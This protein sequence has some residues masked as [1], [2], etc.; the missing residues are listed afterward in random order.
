MKRVIKPHQYHSQF[1]IMH[2][3][4]PITISRSSSNKPDKVKIISSDDDGSL[5][6][7]LLDDSSQDSG[8]ERE[9]NVDVN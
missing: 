6:L 7:H 5:H 9:L 3:K 4:I 1:F 2:E 8:E